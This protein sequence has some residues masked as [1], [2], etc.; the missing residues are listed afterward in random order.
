MRHRTSPACA[1]AAAAAVQPQ[2]Q[3]H[4]LR[5]QIPDDLWA[6]VLMQVAHDARD[7]ARVEAAL[8][9]AALDA[10]QQRQWRTSAPL[11]PPQQ[12]WSSAADGRMW[13]AQHG[14]RVR[15]ALRRREAKL[16]PRAGSGVQVLW[17][18]A[19]TG[20]LCRGERDLPAV[21]TRGRAS[22][23]WYSLQ[24]R[25]H[26]GGDRPAIVYR[27]HKVEWWVRGERHRD[28]GRPAVVYADGT[29]E[30][31]ERGVRHR[32]DG[33]PAVVRADGTR[34]WWERG[35]RHRGD[36]RPAVINA[37][38]D[39]EW[40][41]RGHL[42]RDGD[43]PAVEFSNGDRQWWERGHLHRGADRPAVVH[44]N[45]DCEWWFD[46]EPARASGGPTH[47]ERGGQLRLW[48]DAKGKY[49]RTDGGP[50]LVEVRDDG[51]ERREWFVAGVRDRHQRGPSGEHLPAVEEDCGVGGSRREWYVCDRRHRESSDHKGGL[52]AVE[53]DVLG[54]RRREWYWN[55]LPHRENDLPAMVEVCTTLVEHKR[56]VRS[57][58]W[59]Y[60]LRHRDGGRP[61]IKDTRAGSGGV[62]WYVAGKWYSSSEAARAA[63]AAGPKGC[64]PMR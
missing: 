60:G 48:L 18:D 9:A 61:A 39:R 10:L 27:D 57:E 35:Q 50:A 43:R 56:A 59:R 26:R 23:K 13:A 34:E 6:D 45:G 32:G 7:L 54:V 36:G 29:C 2:Q 8:G 46:G 63:A 24:H 12:H 42:H 33:R 47:V 17:E 1:A 37:D 44:A 31:W 41:E 38:G 4:V 64:F 58:W 16:P 52:P 21:V 19:T 15:V 22:Y 51:S 20:R 53:I 11:L 28:C 14:L 62:S 25:Q 3:W 55:G 49:H 5:R 30:W 40:W